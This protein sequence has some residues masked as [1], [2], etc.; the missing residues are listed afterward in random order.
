[1]PYVFAEQW[2]RE[3]E[4]LAGVEA[5]MDPNTIEVL[6]RLKI[7][8]GWRCAEVGAGAGSIA[9]LL[10]TWVGPAGQVVATDVNTQ[11]LEALTAP[12]IQV[13]NHDLTRDPPPGEPFHLVHTRALIEHVDDPA[14][15]ISRLAG[16]LRSDGILVVEDLDWTGLSPLTPAAPFHEV[17]ATAL[18]VANAAAGYDAGFGRRLPALLHECGLTAIDAQSHGFVLR[19]GTPQIEAIKLIIERLAPAITAS[20]L[21][22]DVLTEA[23]GL[24]DDPTF[25][26]LSPNVVSAWGRAA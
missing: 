16:W 19:G 7:G 9:E 5:A 10:A 8:T 4:R 3:R 17:M 24:C 6:S 1:M 25:A 15:A 22:P 23:V 12:N 2:R 11:Y 14:A 20:G 18:R 13:R 21:S 26:V